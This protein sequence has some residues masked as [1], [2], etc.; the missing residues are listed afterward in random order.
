[1]IHKFNLLLLDKYNF[2]CKVDRGDVTNWPIQLLLP[3]RHRVKVSDNFYDELHRFF[4]NIYEGDI[5]I[6]PNY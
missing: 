3:S 1:M 2:Q 6:K 5:Y 4:H